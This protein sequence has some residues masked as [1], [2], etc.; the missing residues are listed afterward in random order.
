MSTY[1]FI[2]IETYGLHSAEVS[3]MSNSQKNIARK[4]TISEVIS[5]A[6]RDP[7]SC[8]HIKN[9][10]NPTMIYG[11]F[12]TTLIPEIETL[13]STSKDPLGRKIRKDAQLLLAG[14][15]SYPVQFNST[16]FDKTNFERWTK[17][18]LDFLISEYGD[19]L[20]SCL[21][22]LDEEFPHIHFY[23]IPPV[24]NGSVNIRSIHCG[25]ASRDKIPDGDKG[26]GKM[27]KILYRNS[28]QEFQN[29][30]YDRVSSRVG[31]LRFGPK[32]IRRARRDHIE[33]QRTASALSSARDFMDNYNSA[34][35]QHS[36][37]EAE[38]NQKKSQIDTATLS[39]EDDRNTL[40]YKQLLLKSNKAKLDI[41][42]EQIKEAELALSI[43][44]GMTQSAEVLK[45]EISA[46]QQER[47]DVSKDVYR[48]LLDAYNE[49]KT[50]FKRLLSAYQS[51][52]SDFAREKE[53]SSAQR[54]C[55]VDL[56][57]QNFELNRVLDRYRENASRDEVQLNGWKIKYYELFSAFKQND[58]NYL[59]K[60]NNKPTQNS[61]N[62]PR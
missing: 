25:M 40:E 57:K 46:L 52:K 15:C 13:A 56:A 34:L 58:R 3:K 19:N 59:N 4:I 20:K 5:E 33:V 22:H 50:K 45:V 7:L 49:L 8:L 43:R 36:Q 29:R 26:S 53:I 14:I 62:A 61:F 39:I 60:L 18:T 44:D 48:I 23:A 41:R 28:M 21:I 55:A 16:E 6:I 17:L 42:E 35:A 54:N 51:L 27:R 12:P 10:Q 32:R 31:Q 2:H 37:R 30:Y 9:P 11:S 1:Q 24:I 47:A 38:L